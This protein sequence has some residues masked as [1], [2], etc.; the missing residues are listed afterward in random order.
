ATPSARLNNT[1]NAIDPSLI[2]PFG[3]T[4]GQNPDGTG[5]CIGINN[6]KIPCNCPPDFNIFAAKL[7]QFA[8]VGNARGSLLSFPLGNDAASKTAR[9]KASI[10]TLQNLNGKGV[11]CP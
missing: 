9:I 8:A 3:V 4:A 2:P 7:S 5:N 6:V 10:V 1:S 11:G